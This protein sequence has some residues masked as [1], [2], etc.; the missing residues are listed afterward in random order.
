MATVRFS[1]NVLTESAVRFDDDCCGNIMPSVNTHTYIKFFSFKLWNR[2]YFS[3]KIKLCFCQPTRP[4]ND[5][6]WSCFYILFIIGY[7]HTYICQKKHWLA[8][9]WFS[10]FSFSTYY[11]LQVFE[12]N[13]VVILHF[14]IYHIDRQ[15]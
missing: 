9:R 13:K 12:K 7:T 3:T 10:T 4:L 5:P 14:I 6:F 2:S 8:D 1:R 15:F 11:I